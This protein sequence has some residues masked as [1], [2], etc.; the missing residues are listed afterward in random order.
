M[1][2]PDANSEHSILKNIKQSVKNN[3]PFILLIVLLFSFRSSVADWYH[4][5]SGS[6]EPTIM[7]GDRVVVDKSAY[8]LELPFTDVVVARTGDIK[9]GDIVIIDSSAA[10]TRLIKRVIAVEG[11]KVALNNNVLF[12]NGE[13]AALTFSNE[14]VYSEDIL[15]HNR[16]IALNPIPSPAKSFNM[17][18]V[19][20]AHVL[21]MGDNRNN[22]VD[23]RYYGFIPVEEV[24]GK[25][26]SVAFS[27][28]THDMY[29]PRKD[30]V[31]VALQ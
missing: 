15:G 10:D 2:L 6:M 17:V 29:L 5:P 28:D 18:T 22:S 30:R 14:Q 27:L 16:T 12:I 21:A 4:V 20:K 31:F 11:D 8:T 25:A 23:S 26:T 19:P 9:R 24:Q 7:V 3:L 13:K 1:I